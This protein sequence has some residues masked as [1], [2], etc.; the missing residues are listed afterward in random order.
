[1]KIA[2]DDTTTREEH[3]VVI[4]LTALEAR[5]YLDDQL[6]VRREMRRGVRTALH[7]CDHAPKGTPQ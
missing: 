6:T 1:M 3:R 5:L 2:H 4:T 7:G